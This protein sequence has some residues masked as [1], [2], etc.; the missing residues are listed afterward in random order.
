MN[1][2][3]VFTAIL[4]AVLFVACD[5][6]S[7]PSSQVDLGDGYVRHDS[8]SPKADDPKQTTD[9][10]TTSVDTDAP[11]D[12]DGENYPWLY[13]NQGEVVTCT[14]QNGQGKPAQC[15]LNVYENTEG[16]CL[17]ICQPAFGKLAYDIEKTDTGFKMELSIGTS[18][19]SFG[20]TVILE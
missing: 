9:T 1:M 19:C 15:N 20:Y 7:S 2:R 13:E 5:A 11:P 6:D 4:A 14:L 12:T 16:V 8:S 18:V 17:A 3:I 10:A